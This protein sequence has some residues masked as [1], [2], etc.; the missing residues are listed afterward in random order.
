M[1]D[2][3]AAIR[4]RLGGIEQRLA[5]LEATAASGSQWQPPQGTPSPQLLGI[6][7]PRAAAVRIQDIRRQGLSY[8]MIAL[9]LT[10]EGIS[11]RYGKPWEHSNRWC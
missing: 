8:E 11:T 4:T 7:D 10:Q 5:A 3:L 1:A 9:Q 6:Y 2:I